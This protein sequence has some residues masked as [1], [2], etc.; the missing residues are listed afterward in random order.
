LPGPPFT[1]QQTPHKM[2]YYGQ[3]SCEQ[4]TERYLDVVKYVFSCYKKEVPLVIN[5]MG[6]VKGEGLLL[7]IDIIR[8]LSPSHIVQMDVCDWKAMPPLTPEHVHFSAGL[9]T[10]GKQQSK[11]KQLGAGSMESWKYSEGEDVSAPQHKLLYVHPEFPRAGVA[12]EARVHCSI[13][14]DMSIL[15]YLG[16]LQSPDIGAVL[17]LHSL[18]PYQVPFNAV[19]LRVI[20]TDVA[21]SNIMYAVNASWV[22]LSCIPEEVRCQTD[23]PVLLTQTPVC[24]CL[25][26]GIVRGVDMEKKLYHIL[27][28]VPPEKLRLVNCLLLGNIAIPNCVL[29]GQQGIEGEIPYVTSDYNYSI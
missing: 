23:G 12:G 28:P 25:G 5:T 24:D 7:L 11:C 14:R 3:T 2:V 10:K 19:A 21:P 9:H 18:V 4:D 29:V 17:P 13:L 20:H 15:G 27:T 26:F 6:W 8:L 22:G 1:H 16:H